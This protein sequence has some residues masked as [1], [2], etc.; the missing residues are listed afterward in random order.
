MDEVAALLPLDSP[1]LMVHG[2]PK[3]G[4]VVLPTACEFRLHAW[5]H[6]LALAR[7][8]AGAITLFAL[9]AMSGTMSCTRLKHAQRHEVVADRC[10]PRTLVGCVYRGKTR[11]GPPKADD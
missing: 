1:L 5:A 4:H 10:T 2:A 7:D 8:D 11:R 9:A 6:L 3:P